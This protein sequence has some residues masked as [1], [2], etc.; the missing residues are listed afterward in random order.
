MA[1][2]EGAEEETQ[3]GREAAGPLAQAQLPR[4]LGFYD[5]FELQE[6]KIEQGVSLPCSLSWHVAAVQ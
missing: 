5:S 2:R 3:T 1:S 6:H 4:G